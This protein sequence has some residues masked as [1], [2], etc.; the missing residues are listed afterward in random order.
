MKM[1]FLSNPQVQFLHTRNKIYLQII[2]STGFDCLLN[3]NCN[4][5]L[6]IVVVQ[7]W[8]SNHA[9]TVFML[10]RCIKNKWKLKSFLDEVYSFVDISLLHFSS[11]FCFVFK[12]IEHFYV[13]SYENREIHTVCKLK[14]RLPVYMS[15][16]K[17]D[18]F[19]A[20]IQ[21]SLFSRFV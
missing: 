1:N 3:A 21:K 14:A 11:F 9:K 19:H 18:A 8:S 12:N 7:N 13:A 5:M 17:H 4:F 6:R 16:T 2:N 15:F 20:W 10:S